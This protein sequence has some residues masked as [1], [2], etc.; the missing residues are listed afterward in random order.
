MAVNY[1]TK[2]SSNVDEKFTKESIDWQLNT[3]KKQIPPL[4]NN[5]FK[6]GLKYFEQTTVLKSIQF[7]SFGWKDEDQVSVWLDN[8]QILANIYVKENSEKYIY[9]RSFIIQPNSEMYFVF[10][11]NSGNTNQV[12][13]NVEYGLI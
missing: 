1:A 6:L 12:W 5:N 11:N 10:H 3:F 4:K 8:K 9:N 7:G 2:Y 13:I